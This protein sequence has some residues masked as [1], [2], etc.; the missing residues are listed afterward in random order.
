MLRSRIRN[1]NRKG[2]NHLHVITGKG[3]HNQDGSSKV[4]DTV[5]SICKG[6]G[7]DFVIQ[8]NQGLTCIKLPKSQALVPCGDCK[9]EDL[10]SAQEDPKATKNP[11]DVKV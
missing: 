6:K 8:C 11:Q 5:I 2:F 4:K 7:L 10:E 3:K 1:D 9:P